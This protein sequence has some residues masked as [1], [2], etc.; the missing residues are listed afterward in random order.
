M[1]PL[2]PYIPTIKNSCFVSVGDFLF[3]Y[4]L[5]FWWIHKNHLQQKHKT[6]AGDEKFFFFFV[7]VLVQLYFNVREK[8]FF[9]Q[10]ISKMATIYLCIRVCVCVMYPLVVI[11]LCKWCAV[12]LFYCSSSFFTFRSLNLS[13]GRAAFGTYK[14]VGRWRMKN[15]R[16]FYLFFSLL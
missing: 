12:L 9:W 1:I 8:S 6:R 11:Y 13:W 16:A 15:T 14:P 10:G 4:F 3:F 2:C 5:V 7:C